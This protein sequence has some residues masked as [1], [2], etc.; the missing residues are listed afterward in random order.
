MSSFSV[1]IFTEFVSLQEVLWFKKSVKL[2]S[3]N[4]FVSDIL[5]YSF[6]LRNIK[7]LQ[8]C[9]HQLPSSIS[10]TLLVKPGTYYLCS[11]PIFTVLHCMQACLRDRN[12]V[13]LSVHPSHA[14]IVRKR[15]HL[16]KKVQ[17]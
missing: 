15:K 12:A 7:L 16:A 8:F 5:K 4:H 13:R 9:C 2:K 11:Q 3:A 1:N 10:L 6:F 14:C 17:L